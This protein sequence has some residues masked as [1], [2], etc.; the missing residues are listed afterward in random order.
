MDIETEAPNVAAGEMLRHTGA[1]TARRPSPGERTVGARR[2][3]FG[4][5]CLQ[6]TVPIGGGGFQM[7]GGC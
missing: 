7:S 5:A 2:L 6:E 3:F 4:K 1:R